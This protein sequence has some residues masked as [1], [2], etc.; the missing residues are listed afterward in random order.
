MK[1]PARIIALP[2]SG[3]NR[4]YAASLNK[5]PSFQTRSVSLAGMAGNRTVIV[6]DLQPDSEHIISMSHYPHARPP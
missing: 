5:S 3:L 2:A 4:N 1:K 6:F